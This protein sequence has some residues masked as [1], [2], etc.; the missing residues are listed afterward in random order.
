M[1]KIIA[2]LSFIVLV[3]SIAWIYAEPSYEPAIA[4]LL[5]IVALISMSRVSG[6]WLNKKMA[7]FRIKAEKKKT[8]V[9]VSFDA[10]IQ[11]KAEKHTVSVKK[12]WYKTYPTLKSQV[13]HQ[14]TNIDPYT[15]LLIDQGH[16]FEIKCIDIDGDGNP[17]VVLIYHCGAHSRG[18]RIFKVDY[19]HFLKQIPGSELGSD[20]PEIKIEDRDND[21]KMEIYIKNRNWSGS[22]TQEFVEYQYVLI[23]GSYVEQSSH[24]HANAADL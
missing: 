13:I 22:P 20:W 6:T 14:T 19:G 8:D 2:I 4:L 5:S 24:N 9:T 15:I 11:G 1:N 7:P 16:H 10:L 17:E 18:L 23:D 12:V 21:N 3:V